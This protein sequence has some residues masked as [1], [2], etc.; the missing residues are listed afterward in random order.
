MFHQAADTFLSAGDAGDEAL[1]LLGSALA[2]SAD[3]VAAP[4][5]VP[6]PAA[7]ACRM[8]DAGRVVRCA[9]DEAGLGR[10][11]YLRGRSGRRYVFCGVNAAQARLYDRAVFALREGERVR[12]SERAA[13]LTGEAGLLY[14]HLLD[15][16]PAGP[17]SV[18][19]DICD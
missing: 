16:G 2:A 3:A 6:G 4:S 18:I 5:L 14:V 19:G 9:A 17:A 12:L 13:P 10:F 15:D 11:V 7:P 8:V 1:R